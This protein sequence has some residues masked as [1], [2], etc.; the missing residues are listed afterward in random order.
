MTDEQYQEI[1]FRLRNLEKLIL[2]GEGEKKKSQPSTRLRLKNEIRAIMRPGGI[3]SAYSLAPELK[4]RAI[5]RSAKQL[6]T[7]LFKLNK[8]GIIKRV[9]H[10]HYTI[11]EGK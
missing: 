5:E 11:A 9:G 4:K 6:S 8:E 7:P 2:S 10:G 3:W 1:L